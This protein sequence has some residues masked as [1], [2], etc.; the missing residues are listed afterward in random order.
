MPNAL[1]FRRTLLS[2]LSDDDNDSDGDDDGS[3]N[4]G[5]EREEERS[6][7]AAP[8]SSSSRPTVAM[9][10]QPASTGLVLHPFSDL[11]VSV[12][13]DGWAQLVSPTVGRPLALMRPTDEDEAFAARRRRRLRLCNLLSSRPS[14]MTRY[15][16]G[17]GGI[18]RG[19]RRKG[20]KALAS[21]EEGGAH[22]RGK[23]ISDQLL[24][25]FYGIPPPTPQAALTSSLAFSP[26]SL[27]SP[28][29]GVADYS[30][31]QPSY[32]YGGGGFYEPLS[33]VLPSS[34]SASSSSAS[35]A[36]WF[37]HEGDHPHSSASF[38][39]C[40]TT[41]AVSRSTTVA[42]Y[43]L[44]AL[45]R[46]PTRVM[47]SSALMATQGRFEHEAPQSDADTPLLAGAQLGGGGVLLATSV[48]GIS[49][50]SDAVNVYTAEC[51]FTMGV[52]VLGV[53]GGGGYAEQFYASGSEAAIALQQQQRAAGLHGLFGGGW[54]GPTSSS[55]SSAMV[56]QQQFCAFP[57]PVSCGA[58]FVSP[59]EGGRSMVVQP[60]TRKAL[61]AIYPILIYEGVGGPSSSSPSSS[62]SHASDSPI[63]GFY[64]ADA[65]SLG[66]YKVPGAGAL[67]AVVSHQLLPRDVGPT[68][69]I[70]INPR[71]SL[72]A[73]A[74]NTVQWWTLGD[75]ALSGAAAGTVPKDQW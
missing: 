3:G 15:G 46:G 16:I 13:R 73:S 48:R 32:A 72:I 75:A 47:P 70:A 59:S 42:L 52:R 4:A 54:G 45:G 11:M 27:S 28:H 66:V 57:A 21:A 14:D 58:A 49:T 44:R 67:P 18:G 12:R 9:L 6:A 68:R 17:G 19:S 7:S 20:G 26:S 30:S 71:F 50:L 1:A 60:A 25:G 65:S 5:A 63:G 51:D 64:D 56:G 33:S 55:S 34:A 69:S 43:D 41:L 53:Y 23:R 8:S 22:A 2:T 38:S 74:A 37:E 24:G 36:I 35:S 62:P 40:G 61:G 29:S 10:P 31:S 39:P